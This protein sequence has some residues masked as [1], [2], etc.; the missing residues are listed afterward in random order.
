M[1]VNKILNKLLI[2]FLVFVGK[3]FL[4]FQIM[5]LSLHPQKRR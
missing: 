1:I 5:P 2:T 3:L 4:E